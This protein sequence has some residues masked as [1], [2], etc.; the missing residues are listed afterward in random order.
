MKYLTLA[1]WKKYREQL[2]LCL[3]LGH[4]NRIDRWKDKMIEL[5]YCPRQIR[6]LIYVAKTRHKL[7]TT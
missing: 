5:G 4:I 3:S 1:E 2:E 7:L 6:D